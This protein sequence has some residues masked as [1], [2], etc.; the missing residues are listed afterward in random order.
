MEQP[1]LTISILISNRPDTV[2]KCLDSIQPL[3]AAVPSELILTDT[4]CGKEVREIIEAY[5]DHIIDFVWCRDFSAAR[6]VGLKEAKG[7]WFMYLDDDEWFEDTREIIDFFQSGEEEN[8]DVACYI[9]RNF[10]DFAEDCYKDHMVDRILR[11]V[12]ELHFEH[13]I[14]EEYMWQEDFRGREI[15]KQLHSYVYHY[16]YIERDSHDKRTKHDRNQ[17]L[18]ELECKEHPEDMRMWYQIITN[19]Y[20]VKEWD[21]AISYALP[22]LEKESDSEYWDLIHTEFLYC[23]E[24]KEDWNGIVSYGNKFF[25]KEMFLYEQF[26]TLQYV[27]EAY[28]Q[29]KKYKDAVI[30]AEDA[31][32]LYETYKRDPEVFNTCQL[33]KKDFFEDENL[34]KML[35]ESVASAIYAGDKKKLMQFLAYDNRAEFKR[36]GTLY[37]RNLYTLFG[38]MGTLAHPEELARTKSLSWMSEMT[39][40]EKTNRMSQLLF[41]VPEKEFERCEAMI[42]NILPPNSREELFWFALSFDRKLQRLVRLK[43]DDGKEEKA[44]LALEYLASFGEAMRGYCYLTYQDEIAA[45]ADIDLSP[46]ESASFYIEDMIADLDAGNLVGA[47]QKIKDIISIVPEWKTAVGYLIAWITD[48]IA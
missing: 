20:G 28:F 13:R 24:R 14:H 7:K 6:N 42:L 36:L 25:K 3:L 10:Y 41:G 11:M 31:F 17:E 5:T 2:K 40:D 21:K 23:L 16:G 1:M 19:Q 15:K 27:I 35:A 44:S 47:M 8:Y 30:L 38:A 48:A 46:K 37:T 18:L 33:M 29:L 34:G 22:L 39:F 4:G 9:Q 43:E 32:Q 45:G 12:P 26:G